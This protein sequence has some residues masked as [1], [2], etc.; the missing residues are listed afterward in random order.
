VPCGTTGATCAKNIFIKTNSINIALKR[1]L[2]PTVNDSQITDLV[3]G[4]R[5]FGD[6]T[7]MKSGLYVF[8]IT[9]DFTIKWDEK[10]RIYVT[11]RSNLQGQMLVFVE[12]LTKI[13]VM[14]QRLLLFLRL[15]LLFE[16][17]SLMFYF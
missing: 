14:I 9:H 11:V 2:S 1:G 3:L 12:I 17:N 15:L 6:V 5:V 13:H 7:L 8:I 4:S 10:T 16:D